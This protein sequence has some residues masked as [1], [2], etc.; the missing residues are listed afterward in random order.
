[1]EQNNLDTMMADYFKE[2]SGY[3]TVKIPNIGFYSFRKFEDE[4]HIGHFYILPELRKKGLAPEL[5]D[6]M[7]QKAREINCT[8]LSCI[9]DFENRTN[10]VASRLVKTY[11]NFGFVIHS[12]LNNSQIIFKKD[13]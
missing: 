4:C 9:V 3:D 1:M 12:M 2:T 13:I 8:Y 10:D 5:G 6:A 11:L 7:I